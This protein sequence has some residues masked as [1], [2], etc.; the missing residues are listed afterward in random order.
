MGFKDVSVHG[1]GTLP[2]KQ[3]RM[4][5]ACMEQLAPACKGQIA[6]AFKGQKAVA[7]KEVRLEVE[8]QSLGQGVSSS[9]I[10]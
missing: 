10:C 1:C 7:R 8:C 6:A 4:R 9:A 5:A 2:P 3:K